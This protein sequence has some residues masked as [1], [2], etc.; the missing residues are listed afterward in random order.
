MP[1]RTRRTLALAAALAATLTGTTSARQPLFK[2][3][4]HVVVGSPDAERLFHLFRDDL[5]L[6]E[7]WPYAK[8][9]GVASGA[10]TLGNAALEF[11]ATEGPPAAAAFTGVAFEPVG[12][13]ADAIAELDRRHVAHGV[14]EP[15]PGWST[16]T[17][18]AIPPA[19]AVF[20]C[21]YKARAQ[22]AERQR[23]ASDALLKRN[24]GALGVTS[25]RE[26]VVSSPSPREA[27]AAWGML[28]DFEAQD[29]LLA[30][31]Q[32]PGIR[33]TKGKADRIEKLVLGTGGTAQGAA[34]FLKARK[35][36]GKGGYSPTIAPDAIGGLGI[37]LVE[38]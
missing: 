35:M 20:V 30:F 19:G 24:G 38:E 17:L 16:V 4:D 1:A 11:R 6:P 34:A 32:G 3:V 27:A 2:Q 21:D 7:A 37:S 14:E 29:G 9:G 22:V 12:D 31:G 23:S 10:V 36:L 5:G 15:H 25:L 26:I 28:A 8:Q 13:A 33:V 18:S